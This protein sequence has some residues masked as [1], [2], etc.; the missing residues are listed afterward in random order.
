M[1]KTTL[2]RLTAFFATAVMAVSCSTMNLSA[3][4]A[5]ATL[6]LT[7]AT[8]IAGQFVTVDLTINAANICTAYNLDVEFDSSLE[9]KNVEGV[10]AT[11]TVDNVVSLVNF[12]GTGFKNDK[13]VST[14]T[15]EV[16]EDAEEGDVYDVSIKN[17][18][19]MCYMNGN[20]ANV[21]IE[22]STIEVLESAKEVTNHVVYVEKGAT[23]S[24]QVALRGD[25][26][27]DGTVSLMDAVLVSG[28]IINIETFDD[29]QEFV[30][31]VNGDS[32]VNLADVV[33]ICRYGMISD[34]EDAWSQIV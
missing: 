33:D 9:L 15:F 19:D 34:Q 4:E 8:A 28:R 7:D 32:R 14:L 26:N 22:N 20:S 18:S 27:D 23:T 31:N 17:I 5:K 10:V 2:R 3:E 11:C 29:K 12:S 25:I 1:K 21:D 30:A 16:S 24:A 6:T 13:V